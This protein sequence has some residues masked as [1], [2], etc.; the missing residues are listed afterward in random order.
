[1]HLDSGVTG[2]G[3]VAGGSRSGGITGTGG[4]RSD[5][6]NPEP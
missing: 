4:R 1:M 5:A 6:R 3:G 2:G